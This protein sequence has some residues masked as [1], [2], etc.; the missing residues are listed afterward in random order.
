M[1]ETEAAQSEGTSEVDLYEYGD[2]ESPEDTDA[3]ESSETE[4]PEQGTPSD[5]SADT[6][7]GDAELESDGQAVGTA[8]QQ[9][10]AAPDEPWNPTQPFTYQSG[11]RTHE[12]GGA[13]L[14]ADGVL[15]I[16]P[17]SVQEVSRLVSLGRHHE[18]V[19]RQQ[20]QSF[21][22]Q[23]SEAK[24]SKSSAQVR[25][26]AT[27]NF[28]AE[29]E[30]KG[31]QAIAQFLQNWMV[32]KPQLEAARLKAEAEQIRGQVER[33]QRGDPEE[34]Q[35][36]ETETRVNT[37]E[38][39]VDRVRANPQYKFISD[40]QLKTF[41]KRL[42]R[43]QGQLFTQADRD[44]PEHG[45]QKGQLIYQTGYFDEELAEFAAVAQ[46]RAQGQQN[47]ADARKFNQQRGAQGKR[48]P[49]VGQGSAQSGRTSGGN[50]R[51]K[52][53]SKQEWQDS[54]YQS[55]GIANPAPVDDE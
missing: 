49:S 19:H 53:G 18:T 26:E 4:G 9:Q 47:V 32:N 3:P 37:I 45:V 2:Q 28:W 8:G 6:A 17:E 44:Y 46:A 34:Q 43:N 36:R 23:L 31:P 55:V 14:G 16:P 24:E 13:L 48:G 29:L 5:D 50:G 42:W 30:A 54:L 41:A 7:D 40:D 12:L 25:A 38:D 22:R 27:A 15:Y 35:A 10:Q 52:F 33:M 21:Q 39:L 1:M 20:I 51:K 11:G